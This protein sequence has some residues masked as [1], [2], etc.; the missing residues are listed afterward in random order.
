LLYQK[1]RKYLLSTALIEIA[2]L[3]LFNH[4]FI[5]LDPQKAFSPL[6]EGLQ[7]PIGNLLQPSSLHALNSN[8][9][10]LSDLDALL[11]ECL[12]VSVEAFLAFFLFGEI[13]EEFVACCL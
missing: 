13:F 5:D 10:L 6:H 2:F 9:R 3:V 11:H 8:C 1:K 4:N 7:V 12:R